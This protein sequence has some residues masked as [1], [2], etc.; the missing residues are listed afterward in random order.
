LTL[1]K[2][3]ALMIEAYRVN[4]GSLMSDTTR[5]QMARMGKTPE[6]FGRGGSWRRVT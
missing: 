1:A 2:S 5:S 4:G 6:N 3:A